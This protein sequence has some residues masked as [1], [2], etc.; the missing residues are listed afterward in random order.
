MKLQQFKKELDRD[1]AFTGKMA[2]D[3]A[4]LI[5]RQAETVYED[6]GIEFPVIVSSTL[7]C[8]AEVGSASLVEIARTL[9]H[10]HQ[11]VAQRVKTMAKLDLITS[12]PDPDDR[13]RTI[14]RLTPKGWQQAN[15]LK[16]YRRD[17][18]LVFSALS[19]EVSADLLALLHQA[20]T[21]LKD[22]PLADRFA[23]LAQTEDK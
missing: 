14:F 9:D 11:L 5:S 7:L 16:D 17:A 21:A 18:A 19:E 2:L 22:K 23:D 15:L 13:R 10:P 12:A 3:F 1:P 4:M 20:V 6:R 8:L